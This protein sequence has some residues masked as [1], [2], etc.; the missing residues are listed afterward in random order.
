[1]EIEE[2]AKLLFGAMVTRKDLFD[3]QVQNGSDVGHRAAF[4]PVHVENT[5]TALGDLL[6]Q[7]A[8][9]LMHLCGQGLLV[10]LAPGS[11]T[12]VPIVFSACSGYGPC[13]S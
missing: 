6:T 3:A 1:M 5:I 10:H 8:Q 11:K 13:C 2:A 7:L 4:D 12:G 9:Y